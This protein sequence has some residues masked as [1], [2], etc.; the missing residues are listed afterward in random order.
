M[1]T[2]QKEYNVKTGKAQAGKLFPDPL[3]VDQVEL[4]EIVFREF[5]AM[6]D[7]IVRHLCGFICF[8]S[9]TDDEIVHTII[10]Y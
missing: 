10:R 4:L 3:R 2:F 6:N 9:I 1:D 5:I 7:V 8:V